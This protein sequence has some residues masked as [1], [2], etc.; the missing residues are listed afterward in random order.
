MCQEAGRDRNLGKPWAA[1]SFKC[2][3]QEK[4]NTFWDDFLFKQHE[5]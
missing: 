4:K 1:R 2:Q 5:Y 3:A